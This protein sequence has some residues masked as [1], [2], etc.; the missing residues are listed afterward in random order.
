ML[1]HS[2]WR[3]WPEGDGAT[4]RARIYC[5]QVF[6][7]FQDLGHVEKLDSGKWLAA[8]R[9]IPGPLGDFKDSTVKTKVAAMQWTKNQWVVWLE[10]ATKQGGMSKK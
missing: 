2:E 7:H 6:S 1:E 9:K 3:D 10:E 5:G 4:L 8:T